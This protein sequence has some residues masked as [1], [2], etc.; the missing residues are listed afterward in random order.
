[1]QELILRTEYAVPEPDLATLQNISFE[2][3]VDGIRDVAVIRIHVAD[4]VAGAYALLTAIADCIQTDGYPLAL[5]VARGLERFKEVLA[6]AGGL[7]V[8]AEVGL[9]GE[10][11]FLAFL[12]RLGGAGAALDAW[13]GPLSEEHDFVLPQLHVEVKTTT[14]ERRRHVVGALD[15]LAPTRE[16]PLYLLSIQLTRASPETGQSLPGLITNVQSSFGGFAREL[17]VRL[18]QQGWYS[19]DS[20]L[21]RT[22]WML[23]TK[24]T[25]YLVDE[26]FPSLTSARLRDVIPNLGMIADVSYS[27]DVTDFGPSLLPSPYSEFLEPKEFRN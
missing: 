7:S 16:L 13:Q 18:Q 9:F 14:S 1:M 17:D 24:P 10:V 15:Q 27:V 19:E 8:Q 20:G 6:R 26:D 12:A 11:M 5:A 21:Y 3:E 25:S 2:T 4:N 23:R 22:F